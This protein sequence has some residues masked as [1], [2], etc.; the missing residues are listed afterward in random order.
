MGNEG[1]KVSFQSP[2]VQMTDV[3]LGAALIG[4]VI[5]A[6]LFGITTLQAYQYFTKYSEDALW[7]KISVIILC[8]LDTIHLCFSVHMIY[9]Y[10]IDKFGEADAVYEIVWS[11]KGLS[12]VQVMLIWLVQALY[13]AR[14]WKLSSKMIVSTRIKTSVLVGI[15]VTVIV[16]F[17]IG[18][19][20]IV[21][22]S[23]QKRGL[24]IASFRWEI[25]LAFGV[26]IVID[27][28]IAGF[29]SFLLYKSQTGIKR[30]D[31][32]LFTLIQYVIS[33][34]LLTSVAA[35][36]Y[37]LLFVIKPD[38]F[39]Y[40]AQEFSMTRLYA[41]SFLAMMN[42]R[43]SLRDTLSQPIDVEFNLGGSLRFDCSVSTVGCT[44]PEG[45]KN[46]QSHNVAG[47]PTSLASKSSPTESTTMRY[48]PYFEVPGEQA[49]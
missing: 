12:I 38:S 7:L 18:V 26:T 33:T 16:A 20:F 8:L 49:V 28:G 5:G 6:V 4:L 34:G 1:C 2:A 25:L 3:A 44:G 41:N 21:E 45:P 13:L 10:L 27:L 32:T 29:M 15:I 14:I 36:I 9:F 42:A 46:S 11:I 40:L 22:I 19:L 47:S 37:V 35:L 24:S 17:G 48:P 43:G 31:S 23:G 30:T 39:L